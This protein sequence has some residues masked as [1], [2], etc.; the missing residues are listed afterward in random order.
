MPIKKIILLFGTISIVVISGNW[1]EAFWIWTPETGK[2]INPKYA[3]KDTPKEQ[4][5]YAYSLYTQGDYKRAI[6]EF[7]KLITHYKLSKFAPEAQYY[8]GASYQ[9]QGELYRAFQNYQKGIETYPGNVRVE[10]TLKRQYEIGE[11]FFQGRKQKVLG[12]ELLPAQAKAVEIF[13]TIVKNAPY[14]KY[15]PL[16]QRKIGFSYMKAG[17]YFEARLAFEKFLKEYP[18]HPLAGDV[19]YQISLCTLQTSP[20]SAYSQQ[21]TELAIEE[22]EDF[23]VEYPESEMVKEAK[24][25][26]HQLKE[27]RAQSLYE[28]AQFYEKQKKWMSAKIYYDEIIDNYP[29]TSWAAKAMDKLEVRQRQEKEK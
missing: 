16:S 29:T 10:E 19:R 11:L 27:K 26:V 7:Q 20:A 2:W 4:F 3:V 5:D 22:M 12:M 6:N 8:L 23:V 17:N 25:H 18:E 21:L 24:K 15:A 9:N 28:I 1:A 14:G 13:E